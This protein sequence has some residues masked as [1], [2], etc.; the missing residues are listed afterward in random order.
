MDQDKTINLADP[1]T[2]KFP[3]LKTYP[4]LDYTP[5]QISFLNDNYR[6]DSRPSFHRKYKRQTTLEDYWEKKNIGRS[7]TGKSDMTIRPPKSHEVQGTILTNWEVEVDRQYS[8]RYPRYYL[9]GD[10]PS[11]KA[12]TTSNLVSLSIQNDHFLVKTDSGKKYCLKFTAKKHQYASRNINMF[13][14]S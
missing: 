2:I 10:L 14:F 4:S 3:I 1:S 9:N 8:S 13:Y 6:E 7:F 5:L 12:W 11:G